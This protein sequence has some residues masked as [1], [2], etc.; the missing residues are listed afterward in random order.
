MYRATPRR[1]AGAWARSCSTRAW[2]PRCRRSTRCARSPQRGNGA[3]NVLDTRLHRIGP[4]P[5][6]LSGEGSALER[7]RAWIER[8]HDEGRGDAKAFLARH[9]RHIGVRDTLDIARV[10]T[11]THKPKVRTPANDDA[12][13]AAEP[14]AA[15]AAN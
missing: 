10:F 5:C 13:A 11:D 12:C 3:S 7:S 6:E 4:P 2:W 8:L 1:S 14:M 15:V 9:G